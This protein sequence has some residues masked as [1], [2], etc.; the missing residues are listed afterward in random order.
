MTMHLESLE[1]LKTRLLDVYSLATLDGWIQKHTRMNGA[2]FSFLDHE[3]Q[4]PILRD[5]AKTSIIVKCAQVGLSELAYRWAAAACC[6]HD[7]FTVI[8]TFPSATDA[9]MNN[10]TRINPMIA[11]SPML[12]SMINP[13]MNNSSIKQFGRNSFLF[14]KGTKSDTAGLSTPANAVINDEYD[15]SDQENV[16]VYVSRLQHKPHKLRKIFSTPT[17]DKYGVSKEAETANRMRQLVRC[18]HCFHV[19]L[20][21]YYSHVVVPGWDAPL[22]EI[23]KTNLHMT[24]W[25]DAY[26]ACPKCGKDPNLHHSRM[27]FVCENSSEQHDANA[28]YVTP[29]SAPNIISIPYIVNR[30]TQFKKLSEFKNQVLGLTSEEKNESITRTDIELAQSHGDLNSSEFHMMGCD[31]GQICHITIG[32]LATDGTLLV[33]HRETVHYMLFEERTAKLAIEYRVIITVADSQPYTE[34]ITRLSRVRRNFWGAMFVSTKSPVTYTLVEQDEELAEGKQALNL[35]KINRTVALDEVLAI[36]KDGMLAVKSSDQNE[37][38]IEHMTSMKR[39]QKYTNDGELIY[40]WEKTDG[41]DHYHMSLMYLHLA[42]CMRGMVKTSGAM[43]AGI[44]M[45]TVVKRRQ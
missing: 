9:E 35:V 10:R 26:L 14:F 1:R 31:M 19:F 12:N 18:E 15:K 20:P 25:R 6:V 2:P 24:N 13:E 33:V 27:E 8:Y 17:V 21:D 28:W 16:T 5:T 40:M 41:E 37:T 36:I 38:F 7:D 39:V 4:L 45:V 43:S 23:V 29:F 3:F 32:R 11:E 22:E 44:P 30:S 42:I 34:L